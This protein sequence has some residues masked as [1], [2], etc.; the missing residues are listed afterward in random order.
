MAVVT[1]I[2]YDGEY[3]ES[4]LAAKDI[5]YDA[6]YNEAVLASPL[7]VLALPRLKYDMRG[8]DSVGDTKVFWSSFNTPNIAPMSTTPALVGTLVFPHILSDYYA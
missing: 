1:I 5:I 7:F 2:T 6:A 4:L 3:I 8:F